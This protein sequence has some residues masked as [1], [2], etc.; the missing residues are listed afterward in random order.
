MLQ[1]HG[2]SDGYGGDEKSGPKE[3]PCSARVIPL[4]L[5][6]DAAWIASRSASI[7]KLSSSLGD[8]KPGSDPALHD[9]S[10]P[11]PVASAKQ[12]S[13]RRRPRVGLRAGPGFDGVAARLCPMLELVMSRATNVPQRMAKHGPEW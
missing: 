10:L 6:D 11:R 9:L 5:P 13:V 3:R 8:L 4:A 1:D 2:G 7:G 12:R